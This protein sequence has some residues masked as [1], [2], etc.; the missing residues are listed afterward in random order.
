MADG[1]PFVPDLIHAVEVGEVGEEDLGHQ[2][3]ALVGAG[4]LEK[5]VHGVEDLAGLAA[6]VLRLVLCHLPRDIDRAPTSNRLIEVSFIGCPWFRN[7]L[8]NQST[9]APVALTTDAHLAL[10]AARN[11]A[12]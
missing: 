5:R 1:H 12:N 6:N 4:T 10:S 7:R 8:Q 2:N 3:M 11:E 9:V